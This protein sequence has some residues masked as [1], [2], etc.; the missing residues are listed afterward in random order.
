[1]ILYTFSTDNA[2]QQYI[3][4]TV[5][6]TASANEHLLQLPSWRPGRYELGNFA[7]NVRNFKVFGEG[8]RKILASKES[9][10]SWKI[11]VKEGEHLKV[12]YQYYA[13]ELNAGSTYLSEE[14]LYVNPVNCCIY[15][16]GREKEDCQ[17]QLNIPPTYQI[18]CALPKK[19][20]LLLAAD[21]DQLADSPWIA[22][23][24]IQYRSYDVNGVTFHLWFQGETK[25]NWEQIINDFSAFTQKQF[26]KFSEFPFPSYHFLFQIVPY[27]AYHGVEHLTSTIILLGPSY[28]VFTDFYT[29]LL[30]VS[31]HELYHAW[32]VKSIRPA[33]MHPY[34]YTKENYSRLGYLCEGVTT[35]MGDLFLLKSSVFSFEQYALELSKQ[36]QKHFDNFA[37]F[38]CSVAEASF[39]T[40][41]DG[42]VPGAPN[43]K[44]SIYTEGCLLALVTDILIIKHSKGKY[45]L[46]DVMKSLYFEYY[47]Q[48]KGVTEDDYKVMVNRY[49]M[50]DLSWLFDDYFYGTRPFESILSENLEEIGI[51]LLHHPVTSY[52]AGKLGFKSLQQG[53]NFIVKSIYP[54]SPAELANLM[55]EDEIIAVNEY[56]CHGELDKWLSYFDNDEKRLTV[57]RKGKLQQLTLPEVN[58]NFYLSYQ[59]KK[60]TDPNVHQRKAYELWS[61]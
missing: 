23:R 39:D 10:D 42:Y 61:R 47:L 16:T 55:L 43:R 28:D 11:N 26:E 25:V 40:W 13:A 46:D 37:R 45:K 31:S 3:H 33:E 49:A 36:L 20:G 18:A 35:Y 29:E 14:Q 7:K 2:A 51:E 22:S 50:T 12:C 30:G 34:D 17:I 58:R 57:L 56:S 9:K 60:T 32:N 48:N 41:L 21:Y 1:M 52:S 54:G 59:L 6:F 15:I 44:V 19:E 24:S 27:K 8:N 38:N 5:E 53:N 4:I